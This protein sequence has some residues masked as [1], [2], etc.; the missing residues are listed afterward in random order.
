MKVEPLAK[1][2]REKAIRMGMGSAI[3]AAQE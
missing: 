1:S 3:G 2:L